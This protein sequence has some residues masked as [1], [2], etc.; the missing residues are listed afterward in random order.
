MTAYITV[1]NLLLWTHGIILMGD[2]D[3]LKGAWKKLFKSGDSFN[4]DRNHTI[5]ISTSP[6][7]VH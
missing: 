7:A 2:N 4:C 6:A 3:G 1:F 5:F